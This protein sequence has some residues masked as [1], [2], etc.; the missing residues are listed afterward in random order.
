MNSIYGERLPG[1]IGWKIV[2]VP[3]APTI[4]SPLA[5]N[6]TINRSFSYTITARGNPAPDF[7]V[8][9]LPTWAT[10]SGRVISGTPTVLDS[11]G[12][13]IDLTATNTEGSDTKTLVVKVVEAAGPGPG[14]GPGGSG[15]PWTVTFAF[16]NTIVSGVGGVTFDPTTTGRIA[17]NLW[18]GWLA[19][20][21]PDMTDAL[22]DAVSQA[23]LPVQLYATY[24]SQSEL[25]IPF[26]NWGPHTGGPNQIAEWGYQSGTNSVYITGSNT[27]GQPIQLRLEHIP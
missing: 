6:A 2:R 25:Q 27:T 7:S 15:I 24:T 5:R 12:H 10:F 1:I 13:S 18:T 8:S 20:Y 26:D 23:T 14:P 21:Q 17:M 4:T 16:S 22:Y 3:V 11:V 9:N 19:T